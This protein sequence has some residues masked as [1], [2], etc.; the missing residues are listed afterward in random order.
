MV[1]SA[2][3]QLSIVH[4]TSRFLCLNF[5]LNLR[6]IPTQC[7]IQKKFNFFLQFGFLETERFTLFYLNFDRPKLAMHSESW[8]QS[9]PP[10]H[11][12]HPLIKK[13][14]RGLES[15]RLLAPRRPVLSQSNIFYHFDTVARIQIRASRLDL[16][17]NG[18]EARRAVFLILSLKRANY[19][20]GT[21]LYSESSLPK[22]SSGWNLELGRMFGFSN[23]CEE[24][25]RYEW[26]KI[27]LTLHIRLM[28]DEPTGF[29]PLAIDFRT[30]LFFRQKSQNQVIEH[31]IAREEKEQVGVVIAWFPFQIPL[32][33][34][35]TTSPNS[36]VPLSTKNKWPWTLVKELDSNKLKN[37]NLKNLKFTFWKT[38]K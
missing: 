14:P 21:F 1:T 2:M 30:W 16:P 32:N 3:A 28:S 19:I 26:L 17:S 12:H 13:S 34:A 36:F 29:T 4:V 8:A 15:H 31:I 7:N 20:L 38:Q 35:S 10:L 27:N 9:T 11:Q 33:P 25:C 18:R 5:G 22:P 24:N 23:T 6:L 37:G